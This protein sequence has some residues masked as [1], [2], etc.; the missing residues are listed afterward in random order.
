[1]RLP[2]RT[3][4]IQRGA[5]VAA[6][7]LLT[8]FGVVFAGGG[9]AAAQTSI[10]A[11]YPVNGSTHIKATNSSLTLGPG[12]LTATLDLETGGVTGN[13]TLPRATG[14]FREL[15]VVPVTAT[16]EFIQAAPTTGQVDLNTGA[17][18]STSHVTLRL[19]ALR[20]AGI[21]TPVGNRCQTQSPANIQLT[22]GADFNVLNGGPLSGTYTIPPFENCLLATP[23][24]NLTIPGSGNTIDLTLGPAVLSPAS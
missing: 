23:L 13:L 17:V 18:T 4:R 14:S 1:M 10:T 6:V 15:G 8:A 3:A 2:I 20:V 9:P 19:S 22:S 7:T 5:S 12:S 11:T 24:I 16:T 21:P